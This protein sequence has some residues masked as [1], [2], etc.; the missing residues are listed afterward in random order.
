MSVY[1]VTCRELG[2]VKIGHARSV[3]K[4]L[5]ILQTSSPLPLTLERVIE[6]DREREHE[7]HRRF[8]GDR[9]RGEWFRLTRAIEQLIADG[10]PPPTPYC[11]LSREE[12]LRLLEEENHYTLR[13]VANAAGRAAA[14]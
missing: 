3:K 1:F 7:L 5:S 13:R 4:R 8:A 10:D 2:M 12:R 11:E 9:V 14:A 6:G